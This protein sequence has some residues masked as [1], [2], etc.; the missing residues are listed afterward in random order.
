MALDQ[1][2]DQARLLGL[3]DELREIARAFGCGFVAADRLLHGGELAVEDLEFRVL[4]EVLQE[5]GAQA[6]QGV[7][8][9]FQE[10][11]ERAVEPADRHQGRVLDVVLQPQPIGRPRRHGDAHAFIVDVGDRLQGRA[12]RHHVGRLD[13]DIG[14]GEGHHRCALW[15]GADQADVPDVLA[16]LVGELA[17]RLERHIGDGHA[18]RGG[19]LLGHVGCDAD[20]FGF[21][22]AACDQQEV[23]EVYAGAQDAGRGEFSSGF[24]GH[25][26][27]LY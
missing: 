13:L 4:R 8:L 17:G 10:L 7:E 23:G 9:V 21:L 19:D 5:A 25:G 20:R 26:G 2:C 22:T 27:S 14:R 15:L 3:L 12:R 24:V 1:A 11:V 16:R 6:R 18:E